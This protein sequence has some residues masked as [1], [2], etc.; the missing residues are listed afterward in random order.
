MVMM[1]NNAEMDR[2]VNMSRFSEILDSYTAGTEVVS[3]RKYDLKN[4]TVPAKS[5]LI[6]ELY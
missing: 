3:G 6:I 2:A 4:I 1:N 5:A